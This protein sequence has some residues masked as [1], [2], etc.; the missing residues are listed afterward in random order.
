[1][2]GL[3]KERLSAVS[4]FL[5]QI[6]GYTSDSVIATSGPKDL[7]LETSVDGPNFL[8]AGGSWILFGQANYRVEASSDSQVEI[9]LTLS[10]EGG[11]PNVRYT[12]QVF[13]HLAGGTSGT[14]TVIGAL[15]FQGTL[16][17]L[18]T[19]KMTYDMEAFAALSSSVL[20]DIQEQILVAIKTT[21]LLALNSD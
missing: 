14:A 4:G 6:A 11:N 7:Q 13:T 19:A 3:S 21:N 5:A 18:A 15:N 1:M 8:L 2:G 16:E 12:R 20:V 10:V 17:S 9:Q